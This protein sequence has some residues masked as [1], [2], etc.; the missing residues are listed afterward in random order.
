M[1]DRTAGRGRRTE[2]RPGRLAHRGLPDRQVRRGHRVPWGLP[3]H[4]DPAGR[5][6]LQG[7]LGPRDREEHRDLPGL[8]P[9]RPDHPVCRALAAA[10]ADDQEVETPEGRADV[11][12]W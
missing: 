1:G 3:V 12:E 4:R 7:R 11:E 8:R 2:D 10:P 5:Q 9:G 6:D